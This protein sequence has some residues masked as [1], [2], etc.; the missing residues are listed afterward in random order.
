MTKRII[1]FLLILVIAVFGATVAFADQTDSAPRLIDE[2]EL[3]DDSKE[4]KLL[5]KLDKI[6]DKYDFD[7]VVITLSSL[8]G[9]EIGKVADT[10]YEFA[11]YGK[12]CVLFLYD[13]EGKEGYILPKGFGKTAFTGV[14]QDYIFDEITSEIKSGNYY[15]A[16]DEFADKSDEFIKLAKDGKPFKKLPFDTVKA[17]I[18]AVVI[19][20]V[21]AFIYTSSLKGQLKTV[22]A[23]RAAANYQRAGSLSLIN[24]ADYFI[25]SKVERT[26]KDKS[27]SS[28]DSRGGSSRKF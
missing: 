12:D 20:L 22:R 11:G 8:E 7:V 16:F 15:G 9:D 10:L 27:S 4:I 19:G 13:K 28:T 14:G 21:V 5:K 3:I 23:Q 1:S 17:V 24:S 6:S 18:I 26:E 25:Y 2:A